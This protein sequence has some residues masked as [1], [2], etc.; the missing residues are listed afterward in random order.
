MGPGRGRVR[1]GNQV[2]LRAGP[3]TVRGRTQP[4]ANA[5]EAE[6][7]QAS[8]PTSPEVPQDGCGEVGALLG[9]EALVGVTRCREELPGF[10][11]RA[12]RQAT[13]VRLGLRA[14]A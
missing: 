1:P 4:R 7:V 9:P 11:G 2:V 6:G 14:A 12:N 5:G 8:A 3:R 10:H 13:N